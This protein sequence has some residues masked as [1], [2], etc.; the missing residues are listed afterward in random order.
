MK[1]NERKLISMMIFAKTR[2]WKNSWWTEKTQKTKKHKHSIS[3]KAQVERQTIISL[4]I[5]KTLEITWWW[6]NGKLLFINSHKTLIGILSFITLSLTSYFQNSIMVIV[7]GENQQKTI[8]F[9][10]YSI[11]FKILNAKEFL[12]T[13]HLFKIRNNFERE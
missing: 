8:L 11:D 9:Y 1:R 12:I 10:L 13:L 5:E 3:P 6:I 2:W 7:R 4:I